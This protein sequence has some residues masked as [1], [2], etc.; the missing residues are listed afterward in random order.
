MKSERQVIV[1]LVERLL[2]IEASRDCLI[3]DN[4]TMRKLLKE[5]HYSIY[6]TGHP[7]NSHS[8]IDECKCR[9]A[10]AVRGNAELPKEPTAAQER[11]AI[12]A[13]LIRLFDDAQ[14]V[15]D[16]PFTFDA[17]HDAAF[18]VCNGEHWPEGGL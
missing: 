16:K 6:E 1:D 17:L 5:C 9:L 14:K 7:L 13:F 4:D 10:C 12:V 8:S 11:A 15:F 2:V 3:K 18:R